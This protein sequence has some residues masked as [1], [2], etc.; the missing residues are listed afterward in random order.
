MVNRMATSV[1]S[2]AR[3]RR[4]KMNVTV[5][6]GMNNATIRMTGEGA[7]ALAFDF[8]F[9][10]P[11]GG[12]KA[13]EGQNFRIVK[14]GKD[15]EEVV[16][17]KRTYTKHGGQTIKRHGVLDKAYQEMWMGATSSHSLTKLDN[18]LAH[19]ILE[20]IT[21]A[22]AKGSGWKGFSVKDM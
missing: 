19:V 2:D 5:V 9:T 3:V 14:E 6:S 22:L 7:S 11:E 21:Q 18:A 16:Y 1:R 12:F 4:K 8:E 17:R 15:G 10:V 13:P 20:N